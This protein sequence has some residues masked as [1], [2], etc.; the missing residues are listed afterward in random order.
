VTGRKQFLLRVDPELWAELERWAAADLRSVN[1][2]VEWL[3]REALRRRKGAR[4]AADSAAP[5]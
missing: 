5:G 2:Q 3:L 4:E 1:A